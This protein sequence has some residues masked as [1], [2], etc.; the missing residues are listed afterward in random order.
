M[1]RSYIAL[2]IIVTWP[3]AGRPSMVAERARVVA[4][5]IGEERAEVD[6]VGRGRGG[7]PERGRGIARQKA[8]AT[9]RQSQARVRGD[10][11]GGYSP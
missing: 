8:L 4:A 7:G 11:L 1:S 5:P 2:Y 3:R 10:V 9:L 6:E